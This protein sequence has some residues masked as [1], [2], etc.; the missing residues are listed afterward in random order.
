M[1]ALRARPVPKLE[2]SPL[3]TSL[4]EHRLLLPYC[5]ECGRF[6]YP[7]VP[8]CPR[9]LA[10]MSWRESAGAGRLWSW[11]VAHRPFAPGFAVPYTVAQVELADQE[12]LLIDSTLEASRPRIG[13]PLEIGY[14][15][16]PRGFTLHFFRETGEQRA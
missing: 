3:W 8:R 11:A 9:C 2:D 15:D 13:L 6:S 12:G 16:D 10:E 5:E 7:P 4:R 1:T 14:H